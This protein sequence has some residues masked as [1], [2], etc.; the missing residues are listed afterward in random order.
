MVYYDGVLYGCK[1]NKN[2]TTLKLK[3]R[4]IAEFI[5]SPNE[6]LI[7]LYVHSK[8]NTCQVNIYKQVM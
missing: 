8:L 5:L 2:F 6:T 7:L 4:S 3:N 1:P